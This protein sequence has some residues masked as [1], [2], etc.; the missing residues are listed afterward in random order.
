M[1]NLRTLFYIAPVAIALLFAGCKKDSGSSQS[2]SGGYRV[3]YNSG[4]DSLPQ[5]Y[6]F[7]DDNTVASL[8]QTNRYAHTT[9]RGVYQLEESTIILSLNTPYTYVWTK[10]GDTLKLMGNPMSPESSYPNVILVR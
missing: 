7:N 2:I 10:S 3:V 9:H 4:S 8:E 5:Y 6:V 1:L